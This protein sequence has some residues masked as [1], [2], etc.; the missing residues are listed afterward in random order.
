[1]PA[2]QT[3]APAHLLTVYQKKA[4]GVPPTRAAFAAELSR[5]GFE[6]AGAVYKEFTTRD[7]GFTLTDLALTNWGYALLR[8]GETRSAV[9]ILRLDTELYSQSWNAWDSL[10][11]AYA[12]NGDR[13]LAVEAY[14]KS[15]VLNPG[16]ANGMAQL[17]KLDAKKSK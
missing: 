12:K 1:L 14:R 15:L 4:Q 6:R 16:N 8:G 10:G 17:A 11:E 9:A 13:E 7:P 2:E 5:Q 3:G